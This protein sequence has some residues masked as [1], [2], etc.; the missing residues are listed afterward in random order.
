MSTKISSSLF[1]VLCFIGVALIAPLVAATETLKGETTKRRDPFAKLNS[2]LRTTEKASRATTASRKSR[3]SMI[4]EA[5]YYR[6]EQR[7]FQGGNTIEDWLA[8]EKEVDEKLT[9]EKR[10]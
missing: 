3:E 7:G 1:D 5:A 4:A 8:A 2:N 10:T 6:A 9:K